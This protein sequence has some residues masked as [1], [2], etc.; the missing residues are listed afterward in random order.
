MKISTIAKVL[1]IKSVLC[2][3]WQAAAWTLSERVV[4]VPGDSDQVRQMPLAAAASP[5]YD[6][7][8]VAPAPSVTQKERAFFE[9]NQTALLEE[10]QGGV[11]YQRALH[12]LHR[13]ETAA[14]KQRLMDALHQSPRHHAARAELATLYIKEGHL[15]GSEALLLEGFA[16]DENHPDFLRLMAVVHDKRDEPEKALALLVKVKDSRKQDKNYVAFLGHLYQETGR[17]ALARQQYFRLLEEEPKNSL[18]LLGVCL[19]LDAEG[20]KA[21]ALEGYYR[22]AKEG[23]LDLSILKYVQERINVLKG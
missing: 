11:S 22:L 19:A 20:Q 1:I 16:L 21:A 23:N 13:G 18:W 14:A 5:K 9:K 12:H 10:E 4:E 2:C 8:V 3:S 15:E 7:G 17:Y 6:T